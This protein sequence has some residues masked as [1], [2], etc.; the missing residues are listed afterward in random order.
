[1]KNILAIIPQTYEMDTFATI[2]ASE[3]H[4]IRVESVT[5]CTRIFHG[6]HDKKTDIAAVLID[7]ELLSEE[8]SDFM[9]H[10]PSVPFSKIPIIAVSTHKP[11]EGDMVWIER[12]LYDIISTDCPRQLIIRRIRNSIRAS[13]AIT[14]TEL[15]KMLKALPA[16]IFLKDIDGKYVFSTQYWHHL[17]HGDDPNWTIRGKTDL[18]IRKDRQNALK[19]MEADQ[20]ILETGMGTSY[21]IEEND[22]GI[23]EF[24]ELIKRPVSDENGKICGI[25]ALI[26]DVT[27][28]E[29]LKMELEKRAKMDP[30]TGLLNKN[31]T[32]ELISMMLMNYHNTDDHCALLMLDI[33]DFKNINDTFGHAEG[34]TVLAGIGQIIKNSCRARDVAGRIGGDEFIIFLRNINSSEAVQGFARRIQD[35]VSAAFKKEACG[36]KV[37]LSIGIALSP[38]HGNRFEELYKAAD[39]ALYYVKKHGKASYRI[40]E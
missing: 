8:G 30:L 13:D 27:P 29:L 33:D 34:D 5:D 31:A 10:I 1:M 17:N 40:F 18:E 7:F 38:Q 32:E 16:C 3:F 35:Q 14:F 28:Y 9:D 25:I 37:S 12:G 39:S 23:R 36:E 26:N 20:K 24:L 22:D 2:I 6:D 19:A 11:S 15:E 21:I 4:I